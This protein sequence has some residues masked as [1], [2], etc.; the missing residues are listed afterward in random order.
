M[1]RTVN[2]HVALRQI[3]EL[4]GL[5]VT[6]SPYA[7]VAKVR[8]IRPADLGPPRDSAISLPPQIFADWARY[9]QTADTELLLFSDASGILFTSDGIELH[10][11]DHPTQFA[12]FLAVPDSS[13]LPS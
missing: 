3:G 6:A 11:F 2:Y 5:P 7:I 10:Q 8:E 4:L 1:D 13:S 9:D 12:E